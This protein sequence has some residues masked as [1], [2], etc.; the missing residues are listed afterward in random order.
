MSSTRSSKPQQAPLAD[1][2]PAERKALGHRFD[3]L[4]GLAADRQLT[5]CALDGSEV[6]ISVDDNM[7]VEDLRKSVAGRIGLR[8]GGMLVLVAGGN[9]LGDSKPLLAQVHGDV[10]TCVAQQVALGMSMFSVT[11]GCEYPTLDLLILL[12]GF[13]KGFKGLTANR[14]WR[15]ARSSSLSASP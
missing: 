8:L 2:A 10:I 12:S 14:G 3:D 13:I 9:G 11:V 4:D 7:T 1:L 15:R 6:Q 5:V